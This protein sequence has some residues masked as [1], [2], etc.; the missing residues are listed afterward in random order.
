M[1]GKYVGAIIL[2]ALGVIFLLRNLG[3]ADIRVF[4]LFSTWWPLILI[5]VGV[6]MLVNRKTDK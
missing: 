4:E 2:I 5:A 1:K 6:S 3:I